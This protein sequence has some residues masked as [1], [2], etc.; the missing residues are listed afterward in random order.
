[1]PSLGSVII[2]SGGVTSLLSITVIVFV[3]VVTFPAI[4]VA[5]AEIVITPASF[6]LNSYL[7]YPLPITSS[8]HFISK[9][10]IPKLSSAYPSI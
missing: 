6:A 5:I 9:V 1:M 10:E 8:L 2:I 7:L 4:S 3:S